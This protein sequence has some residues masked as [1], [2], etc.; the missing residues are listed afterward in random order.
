MSSV[1]PLFIVA[2]IGN[3][4]GTGASAAR[5]FSQ[6]GYK[7]ALISRGPESLNKL[8]K[9]LN[10]HGG[11]AVGFPVQDYSPN[12]IRAAFAAIRAHFPPSSSRLRVAL[13]NAA[14]GVWKPFLETT[15]EELRD[16]L[17]VNVAA[18]FAFSQEVITDFL[19]LEFEEPNEGGQ[20]GARKRGTLL[21]TA[22]L[23]S[24]RGN[25][26][27]S[28][29]AAGKHG[30]RGLSQSLAKEFGK[31]NIHVAH[32]II[33]GEILTDRT[34]TMVNNPEWETNVDGRVDSNSIAK[35]YLDLVQQDSSAWTWEI[36]LVNMFQICGVGS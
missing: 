3:G 23:A 15:D 31:K 27:I 6:K 18:A 2:G 20:G 33:D 1:R 21:F 34:R 30:L 25:A 4:T 32:S 12:S 36:D 14:H 29:I 35:A 28:T 19:K 7:V 13:F 10:Q 17:D 9:E 16:S 11:E 5:L 8:A 26:T 24:I 22:A